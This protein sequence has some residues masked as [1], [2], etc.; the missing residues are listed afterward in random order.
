MS[1]EVA[2]FWFFIHANLDSGKTSDLNFFLSFNIFQ[3][4]SSLDDEFSPM[5]LNNFCCCIFFHFLK[6]LVDFAMFFFALFDHHLIIPLKNGAKC[7]TQ[8]NSKLLRNLLEF[9]E[10]LK[11][12]FK[13]LLLSFG[14]VLHCF[15]L[16]SSSSN[17]IVK[18]QQHCMECLFGFQ[19]IEKVLKLQV[20]LRSKIQQTFVLGAFRFQLM[21]LCKYFHL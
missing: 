1:R 20:L 14:L 3:L 15:E 10:I 7:C 17:V 5:L 13:L 21:S 2:R 12:N 18:F 8:L 19:S 16:K 4:F 9:S 11:P 6:F